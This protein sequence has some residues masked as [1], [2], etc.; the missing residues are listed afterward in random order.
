MPG[1][2]GQTAKIC[3]ASGVNAHLDLARGSIVLV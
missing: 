1:S 2:N 3:F